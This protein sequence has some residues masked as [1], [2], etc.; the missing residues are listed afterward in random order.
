MSVRDSS[1][2]AQSK[3]AR[4]CSEVGAEFPDSLPVLKH[5]HERPPAV[6]L[7]FGQSNRLQFR[8]PQRHEGQKTN[9]PE[10]MN[11]VSFHND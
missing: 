6:G 2:P 10:H 1:K 8:R 4:T 5:L 7:W 11:H 9:N 3:S